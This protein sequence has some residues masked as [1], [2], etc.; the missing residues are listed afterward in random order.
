MRK[1]SHSG[2]EYSSMS[3]KGTNLFNKKEKEREKYL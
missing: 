1:K 2:L 3:I